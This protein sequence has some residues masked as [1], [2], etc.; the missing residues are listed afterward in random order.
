MII[1]ATSPSICDGNNQT[2]ALADTTHVLGIVSP[3]VTGSK[4]G[5]CS[6][7]SREPRS[8]E[9][10]QAG[11]GSFSYYIPKTSRTSCPGGKC[12]GKAL[13]KV[14]WFPWSCMSSSLL[15]RGSVLLPNMNN[16]SFAHSEVSSVKMGEHTLILKNICW[17]EP[18]I[19]I[20]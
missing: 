4:H 1:L 6:E 9:G 7:E 20:S 12:S 10:T 18:D 13:H 2:Q 8:L 14:F 15:G 19:A 5:A 17:Q 16:V 3:S 11:H